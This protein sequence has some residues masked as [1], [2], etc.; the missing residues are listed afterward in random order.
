MVKGSSWGHLQRIAWGSGGHLPAFS[1]L[2]LIGKRTG[3][4][5]VGGGGGGEALKATI[6]TDRNC[7][8]LSF[9]SLTHSS[10]VLVTRDLSCRRINT[11]I[12]IIWT[13]NCLLLSDDVCM[14]EIATTTRI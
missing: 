7:F 12:T 2:P 6:K 14:K 4:P 11:F 3:I 1:V 5:P 8:P 10:C 9:S 13:Q